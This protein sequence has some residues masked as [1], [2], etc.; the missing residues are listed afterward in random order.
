MSQPVATLDAIVLGANIDGGYS[1]GEDGQ[2]AAVNTTTTFNVTVQ[3]GG[4]HVL[5]NNKL[6]ALN[7]SV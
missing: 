1:S 5:G 6:S 3:G 4:A 7:K 2:P